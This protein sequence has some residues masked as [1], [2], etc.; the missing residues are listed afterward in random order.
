MKVPE[1]L[2]PNE[3]V[4]VG[5]LFVPA[6]VSTTVAVHVVPSLTATEAATQVTE[7]VVERVVTATSFVPKL[8]AWPMSPP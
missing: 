4:P 1:P 2:L 3:T 5:A 8:V 6:A 7:V